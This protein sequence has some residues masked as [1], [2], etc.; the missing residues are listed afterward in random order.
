MHISFI[1]HIIHRKDWKASASS[2]YYKPASLASDGFIHCST[3]EQ[4]V[5]TANQFYFNQHGLLLLCINMN[6]IE[7]EVR[8]EGPACYNDQRIESLFPH[9]YGPLNVSAVVRVVEFVPNADG[10]FVLPAEIS[11]Y[12]G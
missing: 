8:Y 6:K 10:K 12:N 7:P 11:Q 2:G 3:I 1:L 4:T 5:D 9:I